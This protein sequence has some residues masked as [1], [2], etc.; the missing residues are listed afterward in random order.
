MSQPLHT[1]TKLVIRPLVILGF[2]SI[3]AVPLVRAAEL[4]SPEQMWAMIQKQQAQ[5]A[6]L[7]ERVE[8][9]EAR[10]SQAQQQLVATSA[11]VQATDDKV[12]ATSAYVETLADR[13][14]ASGGAWYDRTSLGGYG[15][16]H[17]NF[18]GGN[19]IDF[20]RWVLFVAHEF[21]D[22]IR[23]FSEIELEH[24][25]AGDGKPGEVELEQAF[26]EFDLSESSLARAGLFLVPVGLINETH[27]PATFYG[28]ERNRVENQIIPTTWWEG[29]V[30]LSQQ[31]D[32]GFSF[33]YAMHS[34]L[35]VPTTGSNAY[36]IRS[37]RQKV[38]EAAF[39]AGAATVRARYTGIPGLDVAVTAQYQQDMAQ[40]TLSESIDALLLALH[41]DWRAGPWGVRA[42]YARWDI[43]GAAPAAL[44]RDEQYGFYIEPSYRFATSLGDVG[45]FGRFS[46]YDREAGA[47]ANSVDDYFD[48]GVNWWP[49]EAVVLKADVQFAKPA[50]GNDDETVNLGVGYHF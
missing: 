15:E 12:E 9:A 50:N 41:A 3:A 34:G 27:E 39:D 11:R 31:T 1:F 23:M 14:G 5:I 36:R 42:L 35:N 21:N 16:M 49:H 7:T 18:G 22:R 26:V 25:L 13:G 32:A 40:G 24:S 44:G 10:T 30:S 19:E 17:M 4:P 20:H 45:I 33:D 2:A 43:N 47:G 8:A 28:V 29:G 48:I 6:A 37:G 38:A 46:S